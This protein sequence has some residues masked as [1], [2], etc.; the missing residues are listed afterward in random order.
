MRGSTSSPCP[1]QGRGDKGWE[2]YYGRHWSWG[3]DGHA[4]RAWRIRCPDSWIRRF[5][6]LEKSSILLRCAIALSLRE[7]LEG[8][9]TIISCSF[10]GKV[11]NCG[12]IKHLRLKDENF[13]LLSKDPVIQSTTR[14]NKNFRIICGRKTKL[15]CNIQEIQFVVFDTFKIKCSLIFLSFDKASLWSNVWTVASQV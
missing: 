6:I 13:R 12:C 3:S 11:S 15:R 5:I 2:L 10:L 9:K 7:T 8:G 4:N 14:L 1:L